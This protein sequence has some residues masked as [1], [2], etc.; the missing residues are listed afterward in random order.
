MQWTTTTQQCSWARITC[1]CGRAILGNPFSK[2]C[3][4]F[5]VIVSICKNVVHII[6]VSDSSFLECIVKSPFICIIMYMTQWV[7]YDRPCWQFYSKLAESLQT[8]WELK[9]FVKLWKLVIDGNIAVLYVELS[10]HEVPALGSSLLEQKKKT[11][12]VLAVAIHHDWNSIQLAEIG[13]VCSFINIKELLFSSLCWP[14]LCHFEVVIL[15]P[16]EKVWTC[17]EAKEQE[18]HFQNN[19][20]NLITARAGMLVQQAK[21][22]KEMMICKRKQKLRCPLW[23][24]S[25]KI[26]PHSLAVMLI[27]VE[28]HLLQLCATTKWQSDS[29]NFTELIQMLS[30]TSAN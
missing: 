5:I 11:V 16:R 17:K 27:S 19:S 12:S 28:S 18:T 10:R 8:L 2:S 7:I 21:S 3:P 24:N 23:P 13:H 15:R 25:C 20:Q 30:S 9:T 29:A 4:L 22:Y 14:V 1:G 6:L 26:T